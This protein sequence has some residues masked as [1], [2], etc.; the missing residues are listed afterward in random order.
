MDLPRLDH[1]DGASNFPTPG[2]TGYQGGSIL[3]NGA[4]YTNLRANSAAQDDNIYASLQIA[5]NDFM[6]IAF[7]SSNG[8]I[9]YGQNNTWYNSGNPANG[10]GQNSTLTADKFWYPWF[11]NYTNNDIWQINYGASDFQYTPP[12]GFNKIT[13]SQ[14]ASDTSRT[15]SDSTKYFQTVLYEGNGGQQRVGNF[16]PFTDS[17]TVD[18]GSLFP[19]TGYL[20]RTFAEAGDRQKFTLSTWFKIGLLGA[21]EG[22][23]VGVTLFSTKN[24]T[25]NS[26]STWFVVKLNTSNQLVVSIWNDLIT[27]RTFSDTSQWNNLVVAVDTTQTTAADRIKVYI[28]GVQLTDF[29]TANY[30]TSSAN[31]A[32][33]VN[34]TAH[35]IGARD[36][37][38]D[39]WQGY[40]AQTAYITGSQLTPSSFG[41]TDTSSN[42]WVPKDIS[43]LTFGNTGFLLDYSNGSDLGEDYVP[44]ATTSYAITVANPGSGNKYYIDTVLQATKELIEGATYKFDQSDSS[45][46]GHPLRFSTTSDGTHGGGSEYTTGVTTSGTPGSAGAYTQIVVAVGAPVLY[47]YCSSHSGM[48]GTANTKTNND[49][50]NNN[51][52]AQSGDTPTVNWNIIFNTAF[53]G[54]TLSNGNRSLITG[55]SPYGPALGSLGID[56]GKWY[57]EVK[58]TASS[59]ATLY[60]LIGISRGINLSTGNNLGY[61]VGD[62]GYYSFDGDIVTN[63]N[64]AGESYGASYAVNDIIGVALDLDNKTLTFYK[65]NSSQGVIK[66]LLD[67]MYYTAMGDWNNSGTASFEARFDSSM[68]SYS[69]PTDHKALSQDNITSSD[70]Y[71]TALSWIKNRD[72]T[73]YH[74]VEN[75]V[76]GAG[77]AVYP[78]DVAAASTQ[79]DFIHRFLAGGVQIGE[80]PYYNTADES[81][82]FWNFMMEAT[83]SGSLNEVG[84]INST[85]LV[86][87]TLGMSVGTY[88]GTTSAATIGHGLGTTPSLVIVKS[89]G[90]GYGWYVLHADLTA[91]TYYLRLDT[92]AAESSGGATI[93][94]STS[95]TS[96]VFSIGT[97]SE[98]NSAEK[99]TF[100]AFAPSQFL[101]LGSYINN[102]NA[103]GTFVPTVNSS[104]IPMQPVWVLTKTFSAGTSNWFIN[105]VARIGYNVDNNSLYPNDTSAEAT[106]DVMDIVTGGF[107]LRTASDPNY[108]TRTTIYMAIGT[109][110]I[111]TAGRIIAGR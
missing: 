30:P 33:G 91:N 5:V 90:S 15:A 107:K 27:T 109:P 100:M 49:W 3:F 96:T 44:S 81:Y 16:Q 18:K 1:V 72:T 69:A 70:Q 39:E 66:G 61:Q 59:T 38:G 111:D 34:S 53:S 47:Y 79:P 74:M 93:F 56:S 8:K 10:T 43:G 14:I 12:A 54:G 28:N 40:L 37:S 31:L 9:W 50:T 25:A 82:A 2:E 42:R 78:N 87:T 55:S 20:S 26:E 21:N 52:V 17:F 32:W 102:N 84:S 67:G 97:N 4:S 77:T 45:N 103:N 76:M 48:G 58:V 60:C 24:G 108:L 22:G 57:W 64:G 62:Y 106:S 23:G 7:D 89:M 65:N 86:D 92:N 95:P 35:Y 105:D 75:R 101:S 83:G 80:D 13:T 104:N 110:I 68:W 85:V 19:A 41:Q 46:A 6:Q 11:G 36:T 51:T 71:I 63:N 73:D 99:Y 98:I 29:G 94:N 88:T